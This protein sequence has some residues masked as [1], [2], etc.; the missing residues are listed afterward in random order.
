MELAGLCNLARETKSQWHELLQ[1]WNVEIIKGLQKKVKVQAPFTKD[2]LLL[3]IVNI[4]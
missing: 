4:T 1:M 3:N 2:N